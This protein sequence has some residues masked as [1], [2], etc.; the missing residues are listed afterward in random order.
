ME[1]T[2]QDLADLV[3]AALPTTALV[4]ILWI[5]LKVV[6]LGP[7]SK[8]VAERDAATKGA[9]RQAQDAL[10]KAEQKAAEYEAALRTARGE[11]LRAQDAERQ[12]LRREQSQAVQSAKEQAGALIADARKQIAG[13]AAAAR[14]SLAAE[15]SRIA[16][17]L[18]AAVLRGSR[19]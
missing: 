11:I 16:D 4:V 19:N 7:M 14:A 12:E 2:L 18:A 17:A 13:E 1:K 6:L 3:L 8:T 15:T 5:Y 9:V 10:T